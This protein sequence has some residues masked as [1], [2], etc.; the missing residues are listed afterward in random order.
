[1]LASP[2]SLW[3][4]M[5]SP[6]LAAYCRKQWR[7]RPYTE[8]YLHGDASL[9]FSLAR[10]VAHKIFTLSFVFKMVISIIVLNDILSCDTNKNS[11]FSF[12]L[13]EVIG[14]IQLS[15]HPFRELLW[16]PYPKRLFHVCN[17][18]QRVISQIYLQQTQSHCHYLL[19]TFFAPIFSPFF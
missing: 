1:M 7:E 15:P 18:I 12:F 9:H 4:A 5:V 16:Q 14:P 17:T 3:P 10:S 13:K 6:L 8:G 19:I 2:S 11:L